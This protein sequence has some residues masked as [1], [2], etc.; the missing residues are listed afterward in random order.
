M[1]TTLTLDDDVAAKLAQLCRRNRTSLKKTVNSV[2][3][4]GLAAQERREVAARRF[5]IDTF[6]SPFRSGVDPMRLNQL[7]DELEAE[8]FTKTRAVKRRG[9]A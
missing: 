8:A 5:R 2:L 9:P 3:R 1:R 4:R 6:R 7:S